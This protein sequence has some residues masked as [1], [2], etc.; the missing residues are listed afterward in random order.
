MTL[1]RYRRRSLVGDYVRSSVG[2]GAAVVVLS[3]LPESWLVW[4]IF[5]TIGSLFGI[6][7]LRTLQRQ[8]SVFSLSDEGITCRDYRTRRIT[9]RDLENLK[10]R[11]FGAR[12]RA[13]KDRLA[14]LQLTLEGGG[15][16]LV[17]ESS[18]ESFE[19]VT[20]RAARALRDNQKSSDSTTA[21]NLL[22]IGIDADSAGPPPPID[23]A[24]FT[25]PGLSGASGEA[26]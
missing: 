5:G 17:L 26:S 18:L 8:F 7:G 13:T 2:V 21:G 6:F 15:V 10:V 24:A 19:Y 14:F 1:L 23:A 4:A 16:R 11:F 20:W 12:R 3:P 9:W 22:A 25:D